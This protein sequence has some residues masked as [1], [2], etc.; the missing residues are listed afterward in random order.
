M[1][2]GRD[3]MEQ[4]A[5]KTE[6]G[7]RGAVEQRADAVEG[8]PPVVPRSE[9]GARPPRLSESM[10]VPAALAVIHHTAMPLGHTHSACCVQLRN[11]QRLHMDERGWNDI[12]YNFLIGPDGTVYEGRGWGVEGAHTRMFNNKALGIALMGCFTDSAPSLEA[13]SSARRL[14]HCGVSLGYLLPAFTLK[15]HRDLGSTQCPGDKLHSSIR[16][17]ASYRP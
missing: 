11:I 3:R 6:S 10:Q 17:W 4:A 9:W 12:G 13:L 7:D 16:Q 1:R 14:L 2:V 5:D 8:C 15:G